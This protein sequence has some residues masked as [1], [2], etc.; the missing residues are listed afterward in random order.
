VLVTVVM[1]FHV[2]GLLSTVDAVMK[3]RTPQGT[4]AW[5]AV[6]NTVPY[7]A[8]PAYWV[9][10]R[11]RFHGYVE[12]RRQL[13]NPETR[14]RVRQVRKRLQP[15]FAPA[16]SY[17]ESSAGTVSDR[18]VAFPYLTGNSVELLVDGEAT[19]ASLLEGIDRAAE[20]VLFQFF[21][22]HD[23][24]IGRE[25]Q[26]RLLARAR[27]GVRVYFLYDEVG[28]Y[29]LPRAYL[30][31]LKAAGVE[32]SPFNT[33]KGPKNRFQLNFRN[34]RK[35]VV[36]DG[37]EAWLGGHNVGDEYLGKDPKIGPWRDTHIRIA[38]PAVL[39]AQAAFQDDWEWATGAHLG[40]SWEPV[41]APDGQN[42]EVLV[43]PSGPADALET[44]TLL[45]THAIN[46]ATRRIWIA[47]PYFV[48]DPGMIAALQLAGLRGVD[49]RIL[50]PEKGDHLLSSLNA[51]AYLKDASAT[52]VRFYWYRP[53]FLHSKTLLVDDDVSLV[54]SANFDNRSFRLNFELGAVVRD[55]AFAKEMER[56]YETDLA[57]SRPAAS[58]ELDRR[59]FWFRLAVRLAT[60]TA[61]LQ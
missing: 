30:D 35:L 10:G 47:T 4:I 12:A 54:G 31:T 34:H 32:V 24:E 23:D 21:I 59:S 38:G 56:M 52:G 57:R 42:M 36:V 15:W 22:V 2:L 3:T 11:S 20:Y 44:A 13:D 25:V 5:I 16:T 51:F 6:L 41:P 45:F 17:A 9:L 58:D 14:E 53:G 33:R 19:F 49:V 29:D 61:P 43:L 50:I 46:T 8:V 7:I 28:S 39:G 1:V 55:S 40:L 26:R 60:L 18:L 37:R 48:P 27:A